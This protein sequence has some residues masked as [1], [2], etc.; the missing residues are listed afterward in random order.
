M[1][2]GYYPAGTLARENALV[3]SLDLASGDVTPPAPSD[4]LD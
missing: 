2:R 4:A 3:M 1:R